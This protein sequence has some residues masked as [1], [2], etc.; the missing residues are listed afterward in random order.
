MDNPEKET[1]RSP[2]YKF[3]ANDSLPQLLNV[4]NIFYLILGG[5]SYL[6]KGIIRW[7]GNRGQGKILILVILY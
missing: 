7:K 3:P 1:L 2:Y 4:T 5:L 6:M